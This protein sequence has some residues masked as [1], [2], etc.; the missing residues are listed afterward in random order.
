MRCASQTTSNLYVFSVVASPGYVGLH[1]TS[2][3]FRHQMFIFPYI[4]ESGHLPFHSLLDERSGAS[5]QLGAVL[6]ARSTV[7]TSGFRE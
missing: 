6:S 1:F 3:H 7:E 5:I 2:H 4:D